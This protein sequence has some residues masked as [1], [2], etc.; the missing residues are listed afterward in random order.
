MRKPPC[1][2]LEA[3]CLGVL[4]VAGVALAAAEGFFSAKW[5]GLAALFCLGAALVGA[6]V[7]VIRALR[8][9]R[10]MVGIAWLAVLIVLVPS[11]LIGAVVAKFA[12][13]MLRMADHSTRTLPVEQVAME[14][15]VLSGRQLAAQ[16]N[17]RFALEAVTVTFGPRGREVEFEVVAGEQASFRAGIRFHQRADGTWK[18]SGSSSSGD[19]DTFEASSRHFK[20]AMAKTDV[21]T[22]TWPLTSGV[23]EEWIFATDGLAEALSS[24]GVLNTAGLR[25]QLGSIR[26]SHKLR[27]NNSDSISI[28]FDAKRGRE[29][30]ANAVTYWSFDGKRAQLTEVTG[31]VQKGMASHSTMDHGA[32]VRSILEPWLASQDGLLAPS[33]LFSSRND[34]TWTACEAVLPDGTTLIYRERQAHPFLAEYHMWLEIRPPVGKARD[35]FVPM[36]TGGRTAILVG[37]GSTADGI[38]AV[39]V[40]AGRHFNLGFTLNDPQMIPGAMVNDSVPIGAFT[41]VK[42]RLRWVSATNPDDRDA[43]EVTCDYWQRASAGAAAGMR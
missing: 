39:H 28:W 42:T 3:V 34:R 9:K 17:S 13:T 35:F 4:F 40:N 24:A 33:A 8:R 2:L 25:W 14:K 38:P 12:G 29:V 19:T 32:E 37:M 21:P 6:M 18:P 5:L 20:E 7:F 11:A 30:A 43:Y 16:I 1:W 41:G 26:M 36:N 10:W 27:T 15:L 22:I 31:I 23:E